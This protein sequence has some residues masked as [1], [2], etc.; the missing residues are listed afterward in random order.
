M[1]CKK[2]FVQ[3]I[4][5]TI[6]TI[7]LLSEVALVTYYFKA[8]YTSCEIKWNDE[9]NHCIVTY[10]KHNITCNI[11]NSLCKNKNNIHI[12]NCY[13]LSHVSCFNVKKSNIYIKIII[14][15]GII[16]T[17]C[18]LLFFILCSI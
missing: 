11:D 7:S 18:L 15:I 10:Q 5:L 8:Y 17:I 6:F 16:A 9:S 13:S 1:I 3:I 14:I 4:L 2:L 12:E